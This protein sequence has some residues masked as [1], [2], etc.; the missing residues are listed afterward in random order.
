ML[1]SVPCTDEHVQFPTAQREKLPKAESLEAKFKLLC[2]L[3]Y[4]GRVKRR[5]FLVFGFLL[6]WFHST[7][8]DALASVRHIQATLQARSPTGESL[9]I[10]DVHS[11]LTDLV[12]WGYL[13]QEKGRGRRASRYVPN[14]ALVC[15]V[16]ET[17]NT[18][19]TEISVRDSQNTDVREFPNATPHSVRDTQNKDPLTGPGY[20]T[21]SQERGIECT[22]PSA[23]LSVGLSPADARTAQGGFAELWSAYDFKREKKKARDA[24]ARFAPDADLHI[25]VV[26]AAAAWRAAWAAQGKPDAPRRYLHTWLR[27]E[28]YDCEP[29][30]AYVPKEGKLQQKGPRPLVDDPPQADPAL[31]ALAKWEGDVSLFSPRGTFQGEVVETSKWVDEPGAMQVC[32]LL[33]LKTPTGD[34]RVEH[35]FWI[36]SDDAEQQRRGQ[37]F[38]GFLAH[39]MGIPPAEDTEDLQFRPMTITINQEGH[40]SYGPPGSDMRLAA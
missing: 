11:A 7:Y 22:T 4:D 14:W 34:Q 31:A 29:P 13:H 15:S 2:L 35:V 1:P 20:K 28:D 10:G 17:P 5:H 23:S 26:A 40:I 39:A 25:S 24:Y 16:R 21:G 37:G 30:T 32:L 12:A 9:F 6:D 19:S 38:L 8:G 18:T 3:S 33:A 27:D 36:E